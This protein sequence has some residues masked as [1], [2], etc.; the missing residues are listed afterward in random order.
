MV[1]DCPYGSE[2]CPKVLALENEVHD[3]EDTFNEDLGSL[4]SELKNIGYTMYF[5]AG[6]LSLHLGVM[7][8]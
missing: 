2:Y 3:M 5:I 4:R 7:I 8:I 1:H 6:L